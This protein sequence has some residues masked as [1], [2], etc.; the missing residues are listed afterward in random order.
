MINL[1]GVCDMIGYFLSSVSSIVFQPI[2]YHAYRLAVQVF[3][4]YLSFCPTF[5]HIVSLYKQEILW[6]V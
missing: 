3:P 1:V 6:R 4:K 5:C 2:A